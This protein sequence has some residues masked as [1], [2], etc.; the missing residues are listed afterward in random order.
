MRAL[1]A[2]ALLALVACVACARA[3]PRTTRAT[4]PALALRA[5][6]VAGRYAFATAADF[7]L[8]AEVELRNEPTGG[9]DGELR[10]LA[11]PAFD[12]LFTETRWSIERGGRSLLLVWTNGYSG[13]LAEFFPVGESVFAP[14]DLDAD[15][16]PERWIGTTRAWFDFSYQDEHPLPAELT[17]IGD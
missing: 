16:A 8:P 6:D 2:L 13:V 7:G 4:P 5:E 14:L 17:R 9:L 15:G 10:M 3:E 1:R 12:D 11:A